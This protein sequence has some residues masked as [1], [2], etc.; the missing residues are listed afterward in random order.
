MGKILQRCDICKNFHV[1]FVV[2]DPETG[3]KIYLCSN[4]W[5]KRYGGQNAQESEQN[6]AAPVEAMESKQ[7]TDSLVNL[8]YPILEYDPA[9]DAMIEPKR[10][11]K[12][13]DVPEHC[14]V[15]FF[16]EVLDKVVIEHQ[17]RV[18]VDNKWEDGPHPL[19]EINYKDS[20]LAFFHPGVG[21][22]ISAN[23]LEEVI[24]FG[25]QKFIV[26]G[27]CG[28]L[29]KGFA[30]G[31]LVVVSGAVRDE[32]VSYHYLPPNRE[33]K[34]NPAGVSALEAALR[35]QKVPYRVGKTWTTDAPYRET[36]AK[37]AARKAEGCLTVEMEAASMMAVAQFRG[38]VLGQVLYAG[39]DLSGRKWNE[40]GWQHRK[41]IRESLFWLSAEACLR[42]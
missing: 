26:C 6:E 20:R 35:Q 28:V 37:I 22:A 13:R 2:K 9:P 4:C 19:Y 25:C 33:V 3:E 42:L 10:V 30:V 11:I 39:D 21:G 38:A 23:L 17:A 31:H 24:A 8:P 15:C 16:K 7:T 12:P 18:L 41:E 14:V 29:E 32:G 40:R 1:A 5:K 34:A 27:G 36:L